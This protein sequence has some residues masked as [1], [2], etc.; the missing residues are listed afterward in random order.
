[1]FQRVPVDQ[2]PVGEPG[3][4]R[5]DAQLPLPALQNAVMAWLQQPQEPV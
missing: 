4:L 1:M 2:S 3:V 5:L